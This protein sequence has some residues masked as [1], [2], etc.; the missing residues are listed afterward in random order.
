MNQA[1]SATIAEM[2]PDMKKIFLHPIR[3]V[4]NNKGL[5]EARAPK[6]P[7]DNKIPV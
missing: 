4:T 7:M 3:F 1:A 6:I 2:I 5:E